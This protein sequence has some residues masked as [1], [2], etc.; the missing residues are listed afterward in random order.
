MS[1]LHVFVGFCVEGLWRSKQIVFY[2][3]DN[4]L[5][6]ILPITILLKC[7]LLIHKILKR[8]NSQIC[9][10]G[11]YL[12]TSITEW[13]I[14]KEPLILLWMTMLYILYCVVCS[15]WIACARSGKWQLFSIR[16]MCLS[17]LLYNM[18]RDFPIWIFL[19]I[20]GF[21]FFL[22]FFCRQ[23]E[24]DNSHCIRKFLLKLFLGF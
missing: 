13:P 18:I 20:V 3:K 16:L 19:G 5:L 14:N 24:I 23:F 10:Y 1:T 15:L 9:G 4:I 8:K 6:Y 11:G 12:Q 17:F 21:F 7:N 2:S 22:V